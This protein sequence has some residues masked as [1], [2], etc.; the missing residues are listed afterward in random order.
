M[1]L[2]TEQQLEVC[3]RERQTA[4]AEQNYAWA[5]SCRDHARDIREIIALRAFKSWV[6]SYLDGKG[7]P[8]DPD[9]AGN[10]KHGCR[11]SGRMEWVFARAAQLEQQLAERAGVDVLA[12]GLRAV[13][14][15]INDSGGVTGLHLNGDV[16]TWDEL[17]TGGRYETWLTD[18]DEALTILRAA[19]PAEGGGL[20]VVERN[21]KTANGVEV[22]ERYCKACGSL[23]SSVSGPTV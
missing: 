10:A 7:V 8:H 17:R 23:L 15:L 3:E 5:A 18:F 6:H 1:K 22:Q 20:E 14:S 9:P 4:V 16:A 13:E 12:K 21:Y 19:L 11:I 2:T